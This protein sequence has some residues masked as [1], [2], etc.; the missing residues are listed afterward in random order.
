MEFFRPATWADA[1]AIKAERPGARAIVGGT[2]VMVD[3]NFDRSRPD[4]LLDLTGVP[5]L[6]EWSADG[7]VIR[8]GAGVPY[9]RVIAE[10]GVAPADRAK[11][12]GLPVSVADSPVQVKGPPR[13]FE[14]FG[15]TPLPVRDAD[16]AVEGVGNSGLITCLA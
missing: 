3:I 13:V 1:L 8:L 6:A 11:H 2:D 10:L 4:A 12:R 14:G 16:E 9:S 15:V 5:G 7:P